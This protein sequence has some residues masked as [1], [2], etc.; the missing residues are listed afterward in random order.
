MWFGILIPIVSERYGSRR[1]EDFLKRHYTELI[2]RKVLNGQFDDMNKSVREGKSDFAFLEDAIEVM[3]FF[4]DKRLIIL[5]NTG[6]FK[7]VK[8]DDEEN[9]KTNKSDALITI[10][11]NIP[12]FVT[13]IFV[14]SE[15]DGKKKKLSGKY[16]EPN[17]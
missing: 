4:A 14:E 2:E 15:I 12:D 8:K 10:I 5:K 3:P 17:P 11:A 1:E 16:L 13:V 9:T 6:W 7:S